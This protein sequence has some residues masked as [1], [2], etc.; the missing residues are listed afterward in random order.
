MTAH[1][2]MLSL[3]KKNT[4]CQKIQKLGIIKS[5]GIPKLRKKVCKGSEKFL[6]LVEFLSEWTIQ[7]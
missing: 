5:G 4:S 7:T 3:A 1:A 2:K 6:S